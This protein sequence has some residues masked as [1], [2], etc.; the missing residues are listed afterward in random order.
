MTYRIAWLPGDGVGREVMAAART[1][2]DR[3]GLDAEYIH[4]DVGLE[5]WRE[6]GDPLPQRTLDV[7]RSTD[8]ALFGA[9]TSKPAKEA[10]AELRPELRGR[11]LRYCSPSVR[12]R[13][14]LDLHTNLRPCKAYPGNPLN[15]RGDGVSLVVFREST[16][17][18]YA[19]VEIHPVSAELDEALSRASPEYKRFADVPAQDKAIGARIVTRKCSERIVRAAFDYA[20]AH[21]RSSVTLVESPGVLRETGGLMMRVAREVASQFPNIPLWQTNI[22]AMCMWLVKNPK[23][24]DVLVCE[25]LFGDIVSDLCSQ[26]VGGLGFAPSASIG[27][28]YALFEPA[29]GS[30]PK[31]EGQDKV[32]PLAMILAAG[33]MLDWLGEKALAERLD[34]AVASVIAD[35]EVR[36]YD[37]GG[38]ARTSEMARAVAERV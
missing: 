26:L 17:G 29:H 28:R 1:V 10:E 33:M 3:L 21:G 13:Q 24:F 8:C 2:L 20:A 12:F 6:E 19:G 38:S 5:P 14:E 31:Y 27:E 22:D 32:N 37:M 34:A 11:G 23:S 4:S 30:A 35:G 16:E 36:T 9:V 15:L 18:L 25:N 7:L